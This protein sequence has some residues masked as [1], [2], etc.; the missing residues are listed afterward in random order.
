MHRAPSHTVLLVGEGQTEVAFLKHLKS[1]Y[2]SRGCGVAVKIISANGKGPEF[3]VNYTI[4]KS[5]RIASER[6]FTLLDG[7][8]PIT[9]KIRKKAT[10][11]DITLV[12]SS[13]CFEGLLIKILDK[14][15]PATSKE[16]KKICEKHFPGPLT[17][18]G[19]YNNLTSDLL[20]RR[21]NHVSEL[22][23]ILDSFSF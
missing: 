12:E 21:R 5:Y 14:T 4:R 17:Q 1:L 8:I 22:A 23:Q 20:K 7:D 3:I 9:P 15:V 16:C 19:T 10:Q 18:Q 2:I 11:H 13:P 6:I